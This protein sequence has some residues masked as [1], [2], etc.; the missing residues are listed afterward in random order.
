[1]CKLKSENAKIA[2][3]LQT[4]AGLPRGTVSEG[5]CV[6]EAPEAK[7]WVSGKAAL[8]GHKTSNGEEISAGSRIGRGRGG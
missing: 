8:K 3:V 4:R 7:Q 2:V 5:L 6:G 1:M